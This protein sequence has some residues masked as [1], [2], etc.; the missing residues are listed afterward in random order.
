M[1]LPR[2][3]RTRLQIVAVVAVIAGAVGLVISWLISHIHNH[4]YDFAEVENGLRNGVT[5]GAALAA[6]DLFYCRVRA[7]PGC[8]GSA[9]VELCWRAPVCSPRSSP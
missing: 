3:T 2:W 8:A 1:A 5:L 6:V 9:S 7:G 4:P